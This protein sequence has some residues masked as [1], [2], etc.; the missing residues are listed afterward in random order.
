[1]AGLVLSEISGVKS[2]AVYY[3]QEWTLCGFI[4]P[5][6]NVI[7]EDPVVLGVYSGKLTSIG[8]IHS[9]IKCD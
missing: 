6:L 2:A 7:S 1:M 5:S 8:C 9:D 3:V 4:L